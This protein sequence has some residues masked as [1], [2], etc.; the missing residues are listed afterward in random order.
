MRWRKGRGE[1][2][3]KEGRMRDQA[4]CGVSCSGR[5]PRTN[6]VMGACNEGTPK[7]LGLSAAA[8]VGR[9]VLL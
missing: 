8:G 1:K 9:K 5:R 6:K 2:I 3:E 7:N 4:G